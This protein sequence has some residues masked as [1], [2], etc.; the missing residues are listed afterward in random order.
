M[1]RRLSLISL[2]EQPLVLA[3]NFFSLRRKYLYWARDSQVLRGKVLEAFSFQKPKTFSEG[4][5]EADRLFSS[6]L[7]EGCC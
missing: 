2:Q 4:P 5:C 3:S 6:F 1:G 7:Q